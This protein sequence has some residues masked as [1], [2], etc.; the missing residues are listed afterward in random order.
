MVYARLDQIRGPEDAAA[1]IMDLWTVAETAM[2]AMLG[3][4]T[5]AGQAL[6]RDD[7]AY[8]PTLT[9]V[10]FARAGYNEL[11]R[12][13]NEPPT[14]A[15]PNATAASST[16]TFAPGGAAT[17][18]ATGAAMGASSGATA[19]SSAAPRTTG[20]SVDD[21]TAAQ[22]RI[23]ARA[24]KISRPM[25]IGAG[26]ILVIIIAAAAYLTMGGNSKF[27]GEMSTAIDLMTT[28]RT[29]RA[30]V[31]LSSSSRHSTDCPRDT[32][33]SPITRTWSFASAS[34]NVGNLFSA[35]TI[36]GIGFGTVL[37]V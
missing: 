23:P 33:V 7:V 15:A 1:D 27:D 35:C 12:V 24:R 14:T 5:L 11:T 9:D 21:A 32:K 18:A 8:K 22:S 29:P 30:F 13:A 20:F 10:G 19:G 25:M 4:S 34:V 2:R 31:G 3:G 17:G 26:V 37:V 36:P 16:S 6:V 28:G